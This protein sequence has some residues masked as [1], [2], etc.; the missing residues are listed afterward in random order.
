MRRPSILLALF[1]LM[2]PALA[3]PV[4]GQVQS[5]SVFVKVVDDQ[6]ASLPGVTV[7]LTSPVLPRP[8][9][10]V[11]D[12]SGA[13]RFTALTIGTYAV[14]TSLPN[15]QTV[16]REG[17]IVVQNQTVS[18][19]VTMKIGNLNE[20]VTVR[21]ET[22]VVDTKSATVATNLDA[23]LLDTTPGGKD[24]W[25]ILEY[26]IPGLVFDTP[27]VGGNQAGLQRG[28]T[29]RGTPNSQNVQLVNGV[30][31]G[32]PAAI[33]FSMNYYE[34]ATFENV[35]VTTGAQDISMGT[36]G[37]LINMVTRSGT[38]R[39]GG[40]FGG[41]YQ[42]K[43][44]QWDNVNEDLK[45]AGFRPEAQAVDYISN[46]NIQAGGPLVEHRLFYFGNVNNQQTHVNVPGY[47]AISPP[48]IPQITSGND[49]DSTTIWSA[50]GKLT[51]ALGSSRFEGY[52]NYQWYDKPNRGAG[53]SVT[54]DSN[55]KE[56]DTFLISQGTWNLVASSNLVGDT[57]IAYSNTHFP[58]LQKTDQQTIFDNA[59][60]VRLRNAFQNQLM[61]RRRIQITSNWNYFLPEFLGGR[62]ELKFG[63]DNGYTP[64]D[65]TLSRVGDVALTFRSQAGTASQPAGPGNVTIY[66]TPTQ[67]RRA[68][69]N[70]AIYGQD[71]Y[72]VGRLTL[73]AGVRWERVEGSIPAQRHGDSR[74]F[75]NGTLITG[76]NVQLRT[77]GRL[78]EYTVRDAFDEVRNAP[79][80]K[81][82]APRVS[83]TYDL[84]GTGKTVLKLSAGKYYDQIGTGTPGPNPNGLISQVYTWNDINGDLS[85]QPGDAVWNGRRYVGG[86]FGASANTVSIPNPNPFDTERRR[87]WRREVTAG[88]DHELLPGFR[89][90]AAYINR[91]EFDTYDDVAGDIDQWDVA[92][93]PVQVTDPGRDGIAGT[94][95]DQVLTAYSLNP[96][97]SEL[98]ELTIND[99][100]LGVRYKGIEIVGTKRYGNGTTLLAGYTYSDQKVEFTSLE[101]PNQARVNS[102]GQS[103]GR[104][105]NFKASGSA[106][107]PYRIVFGANFMAASGLP[108]TRRFTV[109]GCTTT[110]TAG[111]LRQGSEVVNAE[112]RGSIELP[113]RYQIDLRFGR[114]FNIEGRRFELGM[115][116]YNLTNANTIYAVRTGT[117]RT[118]IRYANDPSEPVTQ[119]PTFMSPTGALGPR[120][121]RFNLT[122]WFGGGASPAGNR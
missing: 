82:W 83:G 54:L 86:E 40:Q 84:F 69:M 75:P 23:M 106:M 56:D 34:P 68:V 122:Y 63:I 117:G 13:H 32:D 93:S 67:I 33:G 71:L 7:T 115:D 72:S 80:W 45:R 26:K 98:S 41:T 112:P 105:H 107:L 77:G 37:T 22:P 17:V 55:P 16:T 95:D 4:L 111:C 103:G 20:E 100:R 61:F 12:A 53:A 60:G 6:G 102:G 119:I 70:T 73:I 50:S 10:A 88:I 116:V 11:T 62:H 31:V 36:S 64:E 65:V 44:T 85:F 2:V 3:A 91:R 27:D 35:Q 58:L 59:A 29:S 104:R 25:S 52:G 109:P 94:G 19:D 108:I 74:Y 9:V 8:L 14:K 114:L 96:G 101:T 39:F 89:L 121:I 79:L 110:V 46:A 15:F 18:I 99:D 118:N 113:A 42:G 24:I 76:L 87:T 51:Y 78:T 30:N 48:Q 43:P 57:K 5:G 90:S 97:F 120:I 1:V 92:Y 28:F 49:R 81:N 21:G 38:N 47:P 66:N